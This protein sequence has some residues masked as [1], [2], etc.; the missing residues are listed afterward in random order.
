MNS[1]LAAPILEHAM[2]IP[3]AGC[4]LWMRGIANTGYGA[5]YVD[6]KRWDAHRLSW[7]AFRGP[8]PSGYWVLHKC[9]VRSCCNPDHLF[10]GPW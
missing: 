6:G 9:D 3:E 4:W 1:V 10:L 5:V 7:A 8:I 2:P